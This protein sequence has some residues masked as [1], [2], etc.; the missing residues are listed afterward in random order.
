MTSAQMQYF[1]YK[2]MALNLR[3]YGTFYHRRPYV[4]YSIE[5]LI[6]HIEE[7]YSI[8]ICKRFENVTY[9]Y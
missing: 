1:E 5:T 4:S 3:G 8:Y 2:P 7:N 9:D 6:K